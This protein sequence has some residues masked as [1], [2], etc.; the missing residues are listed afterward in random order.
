[1]ETRY[2]PELKIKRKVCEE[3]G[4]SVFEFSEIKEDPYICH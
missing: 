1:M 4:N 3:C 2:I